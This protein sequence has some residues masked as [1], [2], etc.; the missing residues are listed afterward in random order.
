MKQSNYKRFLITYA[1]DGTVDGAEKPELARLLQR[2]SMVH[3]SA[4][5][6]SQQN[7][8]PPIDV[9]R[10]YAEIGNNKQL[11]EISKVEINEPVQELT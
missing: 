2:C 5:S 11:T 9:E 3:V 6:C 7:V 8:S 10:L 1:V 4:Q